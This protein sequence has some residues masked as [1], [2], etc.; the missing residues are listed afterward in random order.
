MQCAA[1]RIGVFPPPKVFY[2]LISVAVAPEKEQAFTIELVL[3]SEPAIGCL[4]VC[5][6]SELYQQHKSTLFFRISSLLFSLSS[7]HRYLAQGRPA[8]RNLGVGNSGC[9]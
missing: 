6:Y 7:P 2:L 1:C 8:A 3:S 5:N 4:S 9:F